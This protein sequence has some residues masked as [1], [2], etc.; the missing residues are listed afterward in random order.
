MNLDYYAI[1]GV[2]PEA[3]IEALREAYR[4]RAFEYHPDCGGSHEQMALV[5]EAWAI[6]SNPTT[7][8]HYDS[9]R[10]NQNDFEAQRSA[11]EYVKTARQKAQEY[12]R[13]WPDFEVWLDRLFR[14][15]TEVKYGT[16]H[17]SLSTPFPTAGRSLSGWLLLIAGGIF[18]LYL[19]AHII[20]LIGSKRSIVRLPVG[21]LSTAGGAWLGVLLHYLI[22]RYLG[23]K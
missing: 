4:M 5:N 8:R 12:P 6:L 20:I 2:P 10:R 9:A 11:Q 15:F 21:L 1:L 3:N 13:K 17:G 18:G 22:G 14:D 23:K 19:G 7:R 16:I